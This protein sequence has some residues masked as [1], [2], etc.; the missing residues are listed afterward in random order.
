[1]TAPRP[2]TAVIDEAWRTAVADTVIGTGTDPLSVM[3]GRDGGPLARTV[4]CLL[5]PLVL[6]IRANPALGRPLLEADSQGEVAVLIAEATPRIADA[7][8]WF[9]ELKA[10]RR[11]AGI[12]GGNIQE[13]YFPR[14]F[15]LAVAFGPPGPDARAVAAE[16]IDDIHR[17]GEGRSVDDLAAHLDRQ[18][19]DL[20][21]QL[22]RVW[23]AAPTGDQA[24]PAGTETAAL[25]DALLN[26]SATTAERDAHWDRLAGSGLAARI[27]LAVFTPG[28]TIADL[29]DSCGVTIVEVVDVPTLSAQ[30]PPTR[31][32]L[33][34]SGEERP[35]DRSIASRVSTT[36][37]R[38]RDRGDLPAIGEL[39]DD[40]IVRS[41]APWAL[42]GAV[43]QAAMLVGV[44]VAAQLRPLAP[45]SCVHAFADTM[46]RRL[47]TQAHIAYT[48]RYLL[49]QPPACAGLADDLAVFWRPYMNRLWVRLHGRS[50]TESHV[51]T[52]EFD[53]VA[54]L[55]LLEGIARSVS[56]DQ[57]S[58]IRSAIERTGR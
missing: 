40:E 17:P 12:T 3:T 24:P 18:H 36:L 42:D 29:L 47:A 32:S 2:R 20:D 34:G 48:R 28:S 52:A 23:A 5:D 53:S 33:R 19:A 16:M 27:G 54:L 38:S 49:S 43:W 15:E 35:L 57:R 21:A 4:K 22:D 45:Q 31:P 7:A 8:R 37:R 50:V 55:D 30:S 56:Y 58:R 9:A 25:L 41:R 14:A 44:V 6:R 46:S 26:G 51:G 11:A 10:C 1:M 13:Q 39:V